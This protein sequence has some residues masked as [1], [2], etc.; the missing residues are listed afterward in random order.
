MTP[1]LNKFNYGFMHIKR[2]GGSDIPPPIKHIPIFIEKQHPAFTFF[3]NTSL[4][5]FPLSHRIETFSFWSYSYHYSSLEDIRRSR[6]EFFA[7][8]VLPEFLS[9]V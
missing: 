8:A 1:K 6:T 4:P 3:D 2:G 5:G 7:F 9:F